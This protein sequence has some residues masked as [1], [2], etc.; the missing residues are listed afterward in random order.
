MT[1]IW[2]LTRENLLKSNQA[3]RLSDEAE[4]L[5]IKLRHIC[6]RGFELV[7]PAEKPNRVW[8]KGRYVK[9]PDCVI[10]RVTGTSYFEF[11]LI[12]FFE[13]NG[14]LVM[15]TADSIEAAEDKLLSLQTLAKNGIKIPKSILAKFPVDVEYVTE[16]L[17]YPLIL[18]TVLGAKGEGVMMFENERQLKDVC[19]IF[20]NATE[21]KTN[22]IFQQFI[23]KSFGKDIRV[24]VIGGKAYGAAMRKG[25]EGNF[26][27]NVAAGGKALKYDL[28]SDLEKIA[29]DAANSL[30][31][32]IAGVDILIG[33]DGYYVGEVN[34]SP[35][36]NDYQD[37]TG[38]NIPGVILE[39]A[40]NN[41]AK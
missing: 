41:I 26:K 2:V 24:M 33:E 7:E 18:K 32:K 27:A 16:K 4:K 37:L 23:K 39:Y 19:T 17:G 25:A 34:S 6:A 5:G 14:V 38:I 29:V 13:A 30:D 1:R 9:L 8:Y 15:N 35:A 28:N 21:G 31:L 22:L 20:Q 10:T 36:F 3:R 40:I 11:A 12:R